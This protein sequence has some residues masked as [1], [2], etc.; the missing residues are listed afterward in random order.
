MQSVEIKLID[1]KV[2]ITTNTSSSD[3]YILDEEG[4]PEIDQP[5]GKPS[6][7]IRREVLIQGFKSVRHAAAESVVKPEIAS[8]YMYTK[9]DSIYFVS[10]DAFRL[11][12]TR[13]LSKEE[14]KDDV[15]VIMPIKN[16]E[17]V[18]RVM[19]SVSDTVIEMYTQNGVIYL[20]TEGVLVRMNG[21]KGAHFL[22]IKISY[23]PTLMSR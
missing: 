1:R 17:R 12:E 14:T 18:T 19:D 5:G 10:T 11:A 4:R 15:E 13:F 16:V 9:D 21:V 22:T 23:Q 2:T 3:I 7:S 6:F 8:V 20:K